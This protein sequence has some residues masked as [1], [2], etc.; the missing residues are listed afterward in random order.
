MVEERKREGERKGGK[1]REERQGG[2]RER[3]GARPWP[4]YKLLSR[5]PH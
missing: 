5:G 1:E 4:P 3:Q 2:A